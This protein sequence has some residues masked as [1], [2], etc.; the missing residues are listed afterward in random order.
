MRVFLFF[1]CAVYVMKGKNFEISPTPVIF[2]LEKELTRDSFMHCLKSFS[3]RSAP[4]R[5]DNSSS[6]RS[7][8]LNS[9]LFSSCLHHLFLLVVLVLGLNQPEIEV[10]RLMSPLKMFPFSKVWGTFALTLLPTPIQKVLF[11]C[12]RKCFLLLHEL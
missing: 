1:C 6:F 3:E 5:I 10:F 2:C 11:A 4:W 7:S 12:E 8:L 9:S